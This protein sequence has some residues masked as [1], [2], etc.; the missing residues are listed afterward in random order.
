MYRACRLPLALLAL[1]SGLGVGFTL[2]LTYLEFAV[3]EA[4]C[5]W[6]VSSAAII[7]AIFV[8]SVVGLRGQTG[9]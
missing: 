2:Y 8:A 5:R 4:W 6:C 7:S 9:Q 1:L 3:I